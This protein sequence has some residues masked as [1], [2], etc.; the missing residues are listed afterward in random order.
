MSRKAS[1]RQPQNDPYIKV[2]SYQYK[3]SDKLGSG[4]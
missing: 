4:Y 3:K 1:S 2:G